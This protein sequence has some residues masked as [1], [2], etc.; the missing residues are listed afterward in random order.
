VTEI[1]DGRERCSVN[2]RY[3]RAF[4]ED[5]DRISR[6]T[7]RTAEGRE[8]PVS[9]FAKVEFK[10]GPAMIRNENGL[11]AG[12]V[13]AD[14]AGRDIGGY[15]DDAKKAVAA[16]V[17]MPEGYS[18]LWSGQYE[19]MIRVRERLKVVVPM[20]LVIIALLLYF[21]TKSWVKTWIVLLAVPFSLIGAVWMLFFLDYNISIAVWVGMIA[22]MGLDAETGVFMLMY[23]DLSLDEARRK[24]KL[25]SKAELEEAIIHGAVRRIRPKMMTVLAAMLGL[26]PILWGHGAGGDL[27]RRIAA[28]MIGGLATSFIL[29]LLVYPAIYSLWK[30]RK[31]SQPAI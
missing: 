20:T 3:P 18:V 25:T 22:L 7:V 4:R 15:V 29:E 1:V 31:I 26:L 10:S 12:Y 24:G 2:V 19:N 23:L 11:L 9:Y 21:N 17:R 16:Q 14:V 6:V 8:L 28:P 13:Y 5:V 30:N 27:M